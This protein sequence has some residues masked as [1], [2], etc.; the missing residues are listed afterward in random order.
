MK[1]VIPCAGRGTRMGGATPKT[2][3][4]VNGRTLL[5][6][7]VRTWADVVDSYVVVV[8]PQNER[9]I[10]GHLKGIK[11]V[12][13][14]V[15][16]APAGLADAILQ[17]KKC[18]EGRLVVN[19]GDCIFKG[20][21]EEANYELGIGVWKTC[22][23][24][25]TVKSYLVRV[26]TKGLIS[27]VEE[28]PSVAPRPANC[29]MGV[30]F[31]DDRVFHYIRKYEGPSGG[32]DFTAVLQTMIDRGEEIKPVWF[33]GDYINITTPEDIKKAKGLFR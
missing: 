25:E 16:P 28:K 10:R 22:N 33:K 1:C 4:E 14:A 18:I 7:I 2:L 11:N 31:L 17:A 26:G 5:G 9:Q 27:S 21:F 29:G 23:V 15:Q 32:G 24:E 3:V 19:L 8:S 20:E 13:F 30:Y 6:W 12:E